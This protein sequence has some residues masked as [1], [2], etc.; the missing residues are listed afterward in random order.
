M[1]ELPEVETVRRGLNSVIASRE[2]P[3]IIGGEVLL[4][5]TIAGCSREF[6]ISALR[7]QSLGSWQ[8]RG[9]Y[10]LCQLS[11]GGWLG[12]HLRMTGRLLW[13]DGK[14]PDPVGKHTRVRLFLT[15]DR[16]LRFDDQRTFGKMWYVPAHIPVGEVI[17]GL[18]S[19]GAEPL[20]AEFT[21]EYL[22]ER[23]QCRHRAIKTVLL[24]QKVVAGLG[25]IYTDEAL[26][27]S[28]IHPTTL[29]SKLTREQI[30]ALHRAI[31]QVLEEGLKFGGTTFSNFQDI[32]GKGGNYLDQAWVFRQHGRPCR[33][34]QTPIQRLKVG[35][36]STH[37]CPH[38]QP[39]QVN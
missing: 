13:Q 17:S 21:P 37:Y 7:G 14:N 3:T 20:S 10:L 4:P 11:G 16:E 23:L 33:V 25:N 39:A 22:A 32:N 27:L 36:R 38:C 15:G 28:H 24:D 31:T 30:S 18:Q 5:S 1:P 12:V 8:R 35:G 6:F 34:C 26:F 29:A 19:M 9:K 2:T